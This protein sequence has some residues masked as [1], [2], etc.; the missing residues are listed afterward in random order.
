MK[1]LRSA[2]APSSCSCSRCR[3]RSRRRSIRADR[4]T[5]ALQPGHEVT[6]DG[7]HTLNLKDADIQALIAT[8]SEITGKNFIVG[9][10]VQ[11]KVTVVSAKPMKPDEIYDVF[12]SVLRVHGFA[13]VQSGSMVKIVPETMAQQDGASRRR[14]IA[15]AR[16]TSSSRRSCRS[17]TSRAA[18]LVPILRPLMPQ[19]GQIIAHASSNSLVVSDRAGNVQRLVGI[20]QRIDT[21]SDAEVEVIPLAHANAAELARTLT[22]LADDKSAPP[23]RSAARVRRYAHQFDPAV[24]PEG[25]AAASMRALVAHLDTP[26]DNGGDTQVIY[27]RYA[28]AKDLVPILQGVAATL[29]GIAPPTASQAAEPARRRRIA[30]DDP[31]PRGEQRAGHQ[32]AAGGVPLARRGRAPARRAP[33]A[34]ADRGRNR[35]SRRPD[36]ERDRRA[37]AAA[38]QAELRRQPARQRDRR[39]QLHRHDARAT[40]SSPPRRIRSASA[41]VSISA[42]STARSR[43]AATRFSSSARWSPRC[44]ATASRTSCR[45]RRY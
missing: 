24:G 14:R 43:S 27:L 18:E 32:R 31:G 4:R 26:I 3:P 1:R 29:T 22:L 11:G 23:G 6:A 30:G 28:N 44:R 21:V 34:G 20:I 17:S 37:V 25:G 7:R 42:T 13:A 39:H 16:P 12:L 38:V 36:R 9:P 10:N 19:G 5:P 2:I 41:T 45:R 15:S 35:R 8:V 33:R 40:T